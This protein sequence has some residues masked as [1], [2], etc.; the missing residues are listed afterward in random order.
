M[1][2]LIFEVGST[3]C[4]AAPNAESLIVG[5]AI[6]GLGGAGLGSGAYTIIAF[7]APPARRPAFTGIIGAAYGLASV[8]GPLI[9]GAFTDHVSWRWCF[10]IN[11]PVGAIS[12]AFIF[13]FFST[14]RTAVPVKATWKERILQ[15]DPAGIALAMGGIIAYTL[16]IEYGGIKYPWSHKTVI[17]LGVGWVLIWILW[18]V[19]QYFNGERSMI[20]PRLFKKNVTY[21]MYAFF[22]AAAFFQVRPHLIFRSSHTEPTA[23][24]TYSKSTT[25][26]T[27]SRPFTVPA[28]RV[29]VFATCP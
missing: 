24:M 14:P 13:L 8:V 2:L 26:L 12:G 29:A 16:F 5:R 11:L 25:C 3:I 27:T 6:A 9:G 28:P 10:Y 21:A 1:A 22:F 15:M 23:N 18:A 20:A 7:S 4:G 19:L 17:G